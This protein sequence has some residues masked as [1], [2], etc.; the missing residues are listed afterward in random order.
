ME[1]NGENLASQTVDID[2]VPEVIDQIPAVAA[3][4]SV[5]SETDNDD[6]VPWFETLSDDIKSENFGGIYLFASVVCFSLIRHQISGN[7]TVGVLDAF[8]LTLILMTSVG[9]GDLIPNSTLSLL[10]ATLFAIL[11][12]LLIG[13]INL[14]HSQSIYGYTF[15]LSLVLTWYQSI[16]LLSI[17]SVASVSSSSPSYRRRRHIAAAVVASVVSSSLSLPSSSSQ[18]SP[19]IVLFPPPSPSL[20]SIVLP[21][22]ASPP[23]AVLV[24]S[25]ILVALQN[26]RSNIGSILTQI[27]FSK[28]VSQVDTKP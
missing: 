13:H 28:S 20:P 3:S 18:S 26:P 2:V 12:M 10:L 15:G 24:L 8:Y 5:E 27:L 22:I 4:S 21:P 7:K 9:Y 16:R 17:D 19:L 23:L 1:T 11:G 25:A 14:F 6:C